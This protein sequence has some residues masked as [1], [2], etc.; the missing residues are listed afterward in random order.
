[1]SFQPSSR[2]ELYDRIRNSSKEQVQLEEMIRLG[3]WGRGQGFPQD[4]PYE[5]Q[6]QTE[7]IKKMS[8][9]R[10]EAAR[11]QNRAA[12][13]REIRLKRM[14]E[15]RKRQEETKRRRE[16]ERLERAEA[17]RQ[18][19]ASQIHYLGAEVSGGLNQEESHVEKLEYLELPLLSTA[20]DL[21]KAMGISIG[22]L[23]F[24]SFSRKVRSISHY[25][26]FKIPKKTGGHR[27][28]SAPMP[29]L[30]AAQTWILENLLDNLHFHNAS[31]G[32][33]RERSIVSNAAPHVGKDVVINLDLADFFPTITYKRIKGM[34][35]HMG[36]S[37]AVATILGLLCSEP[38]EELVEIDSKK[39]FVEISE[40]Y[41]PQGAPT[42]PSVT[43]QICRRMDKRLQGMAQYFDF[44]YTRYADDLTFSAS[45]DAAT[46]GTRSILK[47]A[48]KIIND[49]GFKVNIKK[50]RVIK[51]NK[52]QEVTG[53][54]VND[55]LG[56]NRRDL[57]RFR[58]TL[59]QIE[60]DGPEGKCW[61]KSK[62]L[63]RSIQGYADFI[64]MVN[65]KKGQLYREQV[66]RI[67]EKHGF[68]FVQSK[69]PT[70]P[71]TPITS[72][73]PRPQVKPEPESKP[74]KSESKNSWYKLF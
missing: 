71:Q 2:Q 45:G 3:F 52:C 18:K 58:A 35:L 67:R 23:R 17:W 66:R 48:E 14:Q 73:D 19:K 74:Q 27:L 49:E 30:K 7:L 34:F 12:M 63:F 21:A 46:E 5:L 15:S 13:L 59:F 70:T 50:T 60:Q 11:L 29:K 38:A 69:T 36:Y 64:Y 62:D 44:T 53:V 20:G 8:V 4:P 43:N 57:K 61:G 54:V 28:I 39:W 24:L 26:R 41:L 42:S 16:Q 32:F 47:Y 37:E 68:S 72:D 51:K 40:R 31:H 33:I 22:Q 9:L 10:T 1:M 55:I 25:T 56:V 6:R 65:P